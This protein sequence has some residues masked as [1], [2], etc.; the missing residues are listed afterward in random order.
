VF[1]NSSIGTCKC[2]KLSIQGT[3][4]TVANSLIGKVIIQIDAT[5]KF[6]HLNMF[7]ASI[8][9]T[10]QRTTAYDVQHCNKVKTVRIGV[11]VMSVVV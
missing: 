10:K 11:V 8:G 5:M 6:I 1:L 9:S 2:P 3:P 7:R 4:A